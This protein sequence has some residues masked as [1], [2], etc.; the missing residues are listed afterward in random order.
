MG[1]Q[2]NQ[3]LFH[4]AH[5]AIL[6]KTCDAVR[7]RLRLN[8]ATLNAAGLCNRRFG[9]AMLCQIMDSRNR[10]AQPMSRRSAEVASIWSRCRRP[11]RL[12]LRRPSSLAAS[13]S[14]LRPR[15]RKA[16]RKKMVKYTATATGPYLAKISLIVLRTNRKSLCFSEEPGLYDSERGVGFNWSDT[17]VV[18][19]K[20]GYRMSRVPYTK[21]W[22]WVKI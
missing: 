19:T 13:R 4:P 6:S 5:P 21:E 1:A 7:A 15:S 9:S 17:V 18:A 22:C 8:A 16:R 12:Q 14:G 3:R 10:P 20:S 11:C 2:V